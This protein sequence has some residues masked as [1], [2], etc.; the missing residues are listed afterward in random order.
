MDTD[1]NQ[2]FRSRKIPGAVMNRYGIVLRGATVCPPDIAGAVRAE[3]RAAG[4][5]QVAGDDFHDLGRTWRGP[6]EAEHRTS[7][8]EHPTSNGG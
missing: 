4:W 5:T 1:M 7:N 6:E 2:L 8:I 3:A